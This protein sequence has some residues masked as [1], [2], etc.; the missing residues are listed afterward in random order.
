MLRV[1]L[2]E[3]E[4]LMRSMIKTVLDF[5]SYGYHICGEC[6]D[7]KDAIRF[8]QELK[9]DIVI[10]DIKMNRMNGDKLV[11]YIHDN[12]PEICSIVL[13]GY[14]D[15]KYVRDTLKNNAVDYLIKNELT[16]GSLLESLEK[17]RKLLSA[18]PV[19]KR[20]SNNLEELK[21]NF[22][23]HLITGFY[24]EDRAAV[25]R[26]IK[27]LDI[28]LSPN[29]MM[30]VVMLIDNYQHTVADLPLKSRLLLEFSVCNIAGEVLMNDN[31]G[32]ICHLEKGKFVIL[33]SLENMSG[34]HC[35]S[36]AGNIL[37]RA[38]FCLD[39]Y[40][41][42]SVSFSIGPVRSTA[43]IEE[44]Y[45]IAEK[46]CEKSLLREKNTMLFHD[47]LI[48]EDEKEIPAELTVSDEMAIQQGL[49][50]LDFNM[51]DGVL[52]DLFERIKRGNLSR[53]G[54]CMLFDDLII[55]LVSSCKKNRIA[56]SQVY[57]GN[58][59]LNEYVMRLET[60]DS[61]RSFFREIFSGLIKEL[62]EVNGDH[63]YP[64]YVK[65][66]ISYLKTHFKEDISLTCIAEMLNI[67]AS[68]F[69]SIFKSEVGASF[70]EYLAGLRLEEA[71]RLLESGCGR[72]KE[73]MELSG[74]HNYRSFFTAFKRKYGV[75]P[76]KYL[77]D[78]C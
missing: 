74:F 27:A 76:R 4:L 55:L 16:K 56:L 59:L 2:V 62:R 35:R 6:P 21:R 28:K 71:A 1:L 49:S 60:L 37:Q 33:L 58:T 10:T 34:L 18:G 68:Y 53:N 30:A 45:A 22:I 36:T 47:Q 31:S 46:H 13:S 25:L 54:C 69:S 50:Q 43:E 48:E 64:V 51:V 65:K 77:K 40:L 15:Y 67:N 7:G 19:I 70:T 26:D 24:K 44:S 41:N 39:R 61:C 9:P 14:D 3:D 57:R 17:A 32:I 5:D 78:N 23:I 8:I 20:S 38:A 73:V 29:S 75:N 63:A 72:P 66:A 12:H 11:E 42:L 52:N